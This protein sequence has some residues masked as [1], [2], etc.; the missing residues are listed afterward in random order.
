MKDCVAYG[1]AA[2]L[3]KPYQVEGLL[4]MVN[5]VLAVGRRR[6]A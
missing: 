2:A 3:P 1:F 4:Q 5:G 6:A